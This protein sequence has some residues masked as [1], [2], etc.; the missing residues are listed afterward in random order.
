MSRAPR[1]LRRLPGTGFT[2]VE[3]LVVMGIFAVLSILA[4]GGLSNVLT[5]RVRVEAAFERT[6]ELQR[7]YL[8]LRNDF[9]QLRARPVRDEYD[10]V[11]PALLTQREG[12]VEFTRSGWRNPLS[13]P[14]SALE[15]VAYR[16]DGERQQL[17]RMSWRVLDRSQ[18]SEPVEVVVLEQVEAVQWR[19]LDPVLEWRSEWPEAAALQSAAGAPVPPPRA[20]ELTLTLQDLG[21][22][23]LL[24]SATNATPPPAAPPPGGSRT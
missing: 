17:V 2:L 21:E 10:Q 16:L 14:R 1:P 3:L 11:L 19:F 18:D 20:V 6:A 8:R 24:F 4:Y 13:Q 15:R 9:Q 7:A 23:R 5:A 12:A 22:V